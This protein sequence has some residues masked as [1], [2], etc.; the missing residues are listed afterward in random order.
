M[1]FRT[2]TSSERRRLP[3]WVTFGCLALTGIVLGYLVEPASIP[4]SRNEAS[5]ISPVAAHTAQAHNSTILID[6]REPYEVRD[7]GP[8]G[9]AANLS[10]RLDGSRDAQFI[11]EITKI[12]HQNYDSNI[13]LICATGVRSAAARDL[14]SK[15]GFGNVKSLIGGFVAWQRNRLPTVLNQNQTDI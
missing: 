14:L 12:V 3:H 6:V 5:V 15:H 8:V 9:A 2:L 4:L 1:P 13:T 10:Y 7:G 11:A